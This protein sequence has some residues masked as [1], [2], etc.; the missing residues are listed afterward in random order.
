MREAIIET[1]ERERV[2]HIMLVPAQIIAI[3]DAPGFDPAR[4]ASLRDDPVARRAAPQEHKDRLNALLPD[5]FYELYG[6]TEGFVTIL[7]R[8][9][10]VRKSGSVGVPPP[11][12]EMRIVGEDGRDAA[13]GRGRRDRRPRADH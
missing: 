12:Y 1:I 2:T 4:L 9:D 7:D 10:A 6:L 11:F 8:D 3:L 5:R 13:A